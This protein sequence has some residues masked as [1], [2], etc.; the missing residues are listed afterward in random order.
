MMDQ[1]LPAGIKFEGKVPSWKQYADMGGVGAENQK[2]KNNNLTKD[3]GGEGAYTFCSSV[4][5]KVL[6]GPS[7][8]TSSHLLFAITNELM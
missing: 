4:D 5:G 3:L 8:I 2:K 7:W 6:W 1:P